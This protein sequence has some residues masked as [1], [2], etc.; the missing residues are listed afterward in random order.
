M[1]ANC[2][3]VDKIRFLFTANVISIA[4][5]RMLE[6]GP[7]VDSMRFLIV[8][9]ILP[10]SVLPRPSNVQAKLRCKLEHPALSR[11]DHT[12]SYA[13]SPI[14]KNIKPLA[15]DS[16][17]LLDDLSPSICD[18]FSLTKTGRVRA[19]D[20]ADYMLNQVMFYAMK[21]DLWALWDNLDVIE[22]FAPDHAP[23]TKREK[24][25]DNPSPGL[26]MILPLLLT[27]FNEDR[28]SLEDLIAMFYKNPK[29]NFGLPEQPNTYDEDD[30]NEEWIIP[31]VPPHYKARWSSFAGI[32]VKGRVYRVVLRGCLR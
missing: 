15:G 26:E 29:W 17:D 27:T 2:P 12:R 13:E 25:S 19:L 10:E 4:E 32:K 6:N 28:L 24:E 23:H 16:E 22:V 3:G 30:F 7:I 1:I 18:I 11:D 14:F 9:N 20:H 21:K 8:A 5:L 31:E